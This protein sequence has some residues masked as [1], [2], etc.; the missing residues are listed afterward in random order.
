MMI[1]EIR[2]ANARWLCNH[3]MGGNQA[4]FG[5]RIGV[6]RQAV[7]NWIGPHPPK[8]ISHETARLIEREF[9]R[10]AGWLDE[11]HPEPGQPFGRTLII[12]SI[13][14]ADT[15]ASSLLTPAVEQLGVSPEWLRRNIGSRAAEHMAVATVTGD[16]MRDTLPEG[17][18]VL[19]DRSSSA[20]IE[21]G[22]YILSR[23]EAPAQAW[24]RRISRGIDGNLRITG[25]HPNVEPMAIK[26]LVRSGLVVLGRVVVALEV[27]RL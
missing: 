6:M 22:I 4:K 2:R 18:I 20:A 12:Q 5:R 1:D 3:E 17:T 25:E 8:N 21:D 9:V 11:Q 14:L 10:P 26:T 13:M 16:A 15:K 23:K 19:V 27:R 24:F 7:T